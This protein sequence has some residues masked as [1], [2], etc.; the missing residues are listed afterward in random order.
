VTVCFG[1]WFKNYR[2]GTN[3]STTLL[4]STSYV[5]ILTKNGLGFTLGDFFTSPSGH[6]D[7]R[8]HCAFYLHF[9]EVAFWRKKLAEAP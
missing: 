6:P 9:V 3:F 1:Q 5:L 2:G 8:E 4:H 7:V